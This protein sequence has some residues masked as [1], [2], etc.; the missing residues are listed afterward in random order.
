MCLTKSNGLESRSRV[1]ASI[2]AIILS[3]LE[4]LLPSSTKATVF[5]RDEFFLAQSSFNCDHDSFRA[6]PSYGAKRRLEIRSRVE[7]KLRFL[8]GV[9]SEEFVNGFIRISLPLIANSLAVSGIVL[10]KLGVGA[11]TRSAAHMGSS[12][13]RVRSGS[14][15]G[16]TSSELE[17]RV[18]IQRRI[19]G[20]FARKLYGDLKNRDS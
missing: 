1:M 2:R 10:A 14:S 17:A 4:L 8:R 6:F 18:C 15:N 9:D 11:T 19:S 13:I 7:R 12:S 3:V 5:L 20:Q 16:S